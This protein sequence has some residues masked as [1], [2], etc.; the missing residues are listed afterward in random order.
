MLRTI[1]RILIQFHPAPFRERNGAEMLDIFDQTRERTTEARFL[2]DAALSLGRQW[3]FRGEA[4]PRLRPVPD[5]PGFLLI[6]TPPTRT[7][8]WIAG[9]LLSLLLMQLITWSAL[10]GG[11]RFPIAGLFDLD[12]AI[13]KARVAARPVPLPAVETEFKLPERRIPFP[14]TLAGIAFQEWLRV[15]NAGDRRGLQRFFEKRLEDPAGPHVNVWLEWRE[16]FGQLTPHTL[17]RST[18]Y[19]IAIRATA[20]DQSEWRIELTLDPKAPHRLVKLGPD[21]LSAEPV[22]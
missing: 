1:Y 18:E 15:M 2:A 8:T 21:L 5:A 17:E 6:E 12:G 16:R 4:A 3:L 10:H 9:G 14:D 13:D 7:R 19:D 22:L 11:G 20:G